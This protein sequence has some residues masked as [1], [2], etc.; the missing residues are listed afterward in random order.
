M[1]TQRR[2]FR[3]RGGPTDGRL[4]KHNA[5][6][7]RLPADERPHKPAINKY[8]D[9]GNEDARVVH[10]TYNTVLGD[11][12][13]SSDES[14][15]LSSDSHQDI[16]Q[17]PESFVEHTPSLIISDN[18]TNGHDNKRMQNPCVREVQHLTKRVQ[19]IREAMS[20]SHSI[21]NPKTFQDNVLNAVSNCVNEWRSIVTHYPPV[22][23]DRDET[24]DADNNFYMT[25][26]LRKAAALAVFEMVQ[27]AIQS[28]PLAGAKPGYFKRCGGE[29]AK[30][31]ESF[32]DQVIPHAPL[33]IQLM[34]FTPKQMDAMDTWRKNAQKAALENKPPSRTALKFQQG[35]GTGKKAKQHMKKT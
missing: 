18:L 12:S 11:E 27:Q 14:S 31:V 17:E 2:T 4:P 26:E 9:E 16:A 13:K 20:L 3:G 35:K 34:G 33:L 25:N 10:G 28:G 8:Q 1:N 5:R 29:V 22:P 19:N 6:R 24:Q 32:L 30:V 23:T 15:V 7:R 21:L